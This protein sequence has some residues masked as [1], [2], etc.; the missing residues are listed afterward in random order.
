MRMAND[1]HTGPV[2]WI[3]GILVVL[4]G[5]IFVVALVAVGFLTYY[6]IPS[7]GS[8]MAAK[9]VCSAAF[10]AGREH[11]AEQIMADDVIPASPAFAAITADVDT[12]N[13]TATAS[14][15]GLTSRTAAYLPDRGCV[16]DAEP[17]PSAPPPAPVT[18]PWPAGASPDAPPELDAVV[19]AAF[20]GAGDTAAANARGV[21]II[22]DGQLLALREAPGFTGGV[23]LHGWSMTK[24]V[25]GMLAYLKLREAD[26][27]LDTPVVDAFPPGREPDW[28]ADWRQDDRSKITVA[29]LLYM[30]SG[31]D[32]DEGYL[33]WDP[34]VQ[35]LYGEDDMA[36]WSA[37]H[38][39]A[40]QPGT[41]WEYLSAVSNI[42]AQVVRAQFDT[43]AEYWAYPRTALFD[44]IGAD[45]ATL[46]TDTSGTWAA[47][48]YL[49]A[50]TADWAR[51]GRADAR[52]RQ[53]GG[54]TGP[55]GGLARPRADAIPAAGRRGGIWRGLLVAGQSRRWRVPRRAEGAHRHRVDGGPL[56][57]TGGDGAFA[58][59]GHRPARLDLRQRPIRRLRVHGRRPGGAAVAVFGSLLTVAVYLGA[60]PRCPRR[61]ACVG[62]RR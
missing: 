41:E 52:R 59:R 42:L 58:G 40:A 62:R 25:S 26:I 57:A 4:T 17:D 14:F 22:Q 35:M 15:L 43:D 49:W 51:L 27:G 2:G 7:N 45:T 1:N 11:D 19:E 48:S 61:A 39:L 31:L 33:P 9:A 6:H 34:V 29:D 36:G 56:G 3:V 12:Q 21:A 44:P 24:T 28:A 30:R 32:I 37:A 16:L 54:R 53:V 55:A 5:L 23:P 47:S 60:R 8:G 10:V 20:E 50:S 13:R 46:E 18:D 38:G